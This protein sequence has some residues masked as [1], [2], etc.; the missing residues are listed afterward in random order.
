MFLGQWAQ[1]SSK[2]AKKIN[3]LCKIGT[4]YKCAYFFRDVLENKVNTLIVEN[5]NNFL[6]L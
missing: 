6:E 5:V 4:I 3:I 1:L 2:V